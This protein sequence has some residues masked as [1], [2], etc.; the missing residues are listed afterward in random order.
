MY[1]RAYTSIKGATTRAREK[2]P[3][4]RFPDAIFHVREA[5]Y[6]S[7]VSIYVYVSISLCYIYQLHKIDIYTNITTQK[8]VYTLNIHNI[9][10]LQ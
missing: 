10:I 7:M 4:G 2:R 5:V 6:L 1:T 9:L 3:F 8:E